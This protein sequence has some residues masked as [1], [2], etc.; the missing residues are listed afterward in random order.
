MVQP[1]DS[2]ETPNREPSAG[3]DR[4]EHERRVYVGRRGLPAQLVD[5]MYRDYLRL[6]SAAKVGAL[7]GRTRQAIWDIFQ[8]KKL[9]LRKK[10][11]KKQIKHKG[12]AYSL[13]KGYMRAT[14]GGR[15]PLHHVLWIEKNGPIP[16]GHNLVFRD[17]NRFNFTLRN[18]I[19]LTV[20]EQGKF[21]HQLAIKRRQTGKQPCGHR[22]TWSSREVLQLP[23]GSMV[24]RARLPDTLVDR[25][26]A[27]YTKPLSLA[28]VGRLYKRNRQCIRELFERRGLPIRAATNLPKH[29]LANGQVAPAVPL[30]A[31][32]IETL[33][34]KATKI[35][36]PSRL[37]L[38]WRKWSLPRRR[39]FIARLRIKFKSRDDRPNRPF[40]ANVEPF[41]YASPKARA[42]AR[43]VNSGLDSRQ[44]RTTLKI[45]C[46]GVIWRGQL[47]FWA[48]KVGY[49]LGSWTESDGRPCLH[50]TIW[51]EHNGRDIPA[52]YVVRFAD[53]NPNNF[54]P[55]NL[56]LATRNDLARENQASGLLSKSREIT[57]LLLKR[58]QHKGK[59]N[60]AD[61]IQL[62][63]SH[64]LI[65][66]RAA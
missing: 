1:N 12:I 43:S 41:D 57:A 66:R 50:H 47:W 58:A 18:I 60:H 9:Q 63:R 59:S 20:A 17:G 45:K 29:R 51:K 16:F 14:S 61:K 39:W 21:S 28:A 42:I 64:T 49:C 65:R 10:K 26:Y 5:R 48:R 40:S 8:T 62:L 19:C 15:V 36:V 54:T 35:A 13:H 44:R 2:P 22:R 52:G 46:Q 24:G 56:V 23:P 3:T 34:A 55:E 30:T 11:F 6:R 37:K 7:Y 53:R 27:D 25:M 33:I 32:Q 38:E 31:R 4:L